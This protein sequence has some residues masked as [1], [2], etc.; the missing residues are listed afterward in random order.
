MVD[1]ITGRLILRATPTFE[2]S[3]FRPLDPSAGNAAGGVQSFLDTVLARFE[4]ATASVP[5]IVEYT[6][7]AGFA[8]YVRLANDFCGAGSPP[9]GPLCAVADL[10][11]FADRVSTVAGQG[12]RNH[13]D[14][15][16]SQLVDMH[17]YLDRLSNQ[18]DLENAVGSLELEIQKVGAD[19]KVVAPVL[20]DRMAAVSE[21]WS[22]A[23]D[24]SL[25]FEQEITEADILS[26]YRLAQ[27]AFDEAAL[28][29]AQTSGT[30]KNL[31]GG[32]LPV[33]EPPHAIVSAVAVAYT[34]LFEARQ[35]ADAA[36]AAAA[37]L[38]EAAREVAFSGALGE[39][40]MTA[41]AALRAGSARALADV[42][43]NCYKLELAKDAIERAGD[44]HALLEA[45]DR[46]IAAYDEFHG[47]VVHATLTV[48]HVGAIVNG[49]CSLIDGQESSAAAELRAAFLDVVD[50]APQAIEGEF[51][52]AGKMAAW[53]RLHVERMALLAFNKQVDTLTQSTTD[54][55]NNLALFDAVAMA[56]SV[57]HARRQHQKLWLHTQS[58]QFC[59]LQ[60]Y[61]HAGAMSTPCRDL[62]AGDAL[63]T[64]KTLNLV[65]ST[66]VQSA[67][68]ELGS[69]PYVAGLPTAPFNVQTSEGHV[70]W[71]ALLAGDVVRFR[72]PGDAEWQ[73]RYGW[74]TMI[75]HGAAFVKSIKVEI[76]LTTSGA[77]F[78]LTVTADQTNRLYRGTQV[79]RED[80]LLRSSLFYQKEACKKVLNEEP[81]AYE[82]CSGGLPA[83]CSSHFSSFGGEGDYLPSLY[84]TFELQLKESNGLDVLRSIPAGQLVL[85]VEVETVLVR[86]RPSGGAALQPLVP[87]V[88][89]TAVPAEDGKCCKNGEHVVRWS[90]DH[91]C[92][93]CSSGAFSIHGGTYCTL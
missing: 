6:S 22:D 42:L 1:P 29:L 83:S 51:A 7:S 76:P 49:F 59:A 78:T 81:N 28:R 24:A 18:Q 8:E 38:E 58:M 73:A 62:M 87:A 43:G 36:A 60:R 77:S 20:A 12:T 65:L 67:R 31:E 71:D 56:R 61:N 46:F 48:N 15:S 44:E 5:Q 88:G 30:L 11:A 74:D 92:E 52:A 27:A 64:T 72:I 13:T 33:F 89:P 37:S 86:E 66:G 41:G 91:S 21:A 69:G 40:A 14:L 82:R 19:V 35:N 17:V 47:G 16:T 93:A 79:V 90:N 32:L 84:T 54:S 75:R 10:Q 45:Y 68:R 80:T 39:A 70:D 53:A 2:C 26:E 85:K 57:Y 55:S 23:V 34:E 25:A 4:S 63:T 3:I 50:V 9:G